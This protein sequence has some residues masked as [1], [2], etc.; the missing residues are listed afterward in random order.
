MVNGIEEFKSQP[1]GHG[2]AE[3][4]PAYRLVHDI[5]DIPESQYIPESWYIQQLVEGGV[6]GFL[7]FLGIMGMITWQLY[8]KSVFMF[9]G[10]VSILIIN[11]FLHSFEASYVSILLF[12]A[13]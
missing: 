4:G 6:I 10:F 5:T 13:I 12:A 9:G 8:K 2:L 11:F 1:L 3:S 7:L